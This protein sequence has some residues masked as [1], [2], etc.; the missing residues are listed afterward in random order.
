MKHYTVREKNSGTLIT[1]IEA[2][3]INQARAAAAELHLSVIAST[4]S[5][6]LNADKAMVTQAPKPKPRAA[7]KPDPAQTGL[8]DQIRDS[9]RATEPEP[10]VVTD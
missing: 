4:S 8:E 10:P 1:I 9:E 3:N 6:L 5:E 2:D 7:K